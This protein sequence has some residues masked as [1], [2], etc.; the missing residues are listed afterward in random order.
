MSNAYLAATIRTSDEKITIKEEG[1]QIH[2]I[3]L[4]ITIIPQ[5]LS[6]PL[7]P[8][9]ETIIGVHGKKCLV[10]SKGN[11]KAIPNPPFVKASIMP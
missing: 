5:W 1:S 9:G 2:N 10:L 4:F 3:S 7:M 11:N 6:K 8:K